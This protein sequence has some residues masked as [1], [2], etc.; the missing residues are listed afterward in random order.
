MTVT[1]VKRLERIRSERAGKDA[2]DGPRKDRRNRHSEITVRSVPAT[3]G[4]TQTGDSVIAEGTG[5]ASEVERVSRGTGKRSGRSDRE[6]NATIEGAYQGNGVST[7][8]ALV[9]PAPADIEETEE[10]KAAR[11]KEANRQ[12][13]ALYREREK[14]RNLADTV[15]DAVVSSPLFKLT[16]KAE[17]AAPKEPLRKL[18]NDESEDA[19]SKMTYMYTKFSGLLD[20]ILEAVVRDHEPVQIWQLSDDEAQAL[21]EMQIESGKKDPQAAKVVRTIVRAYDKLYMYMLLGPRVVATAKHVTE[22]KGFSLR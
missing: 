10:E 19:L 5:G 13:Q 20:E 1:D 11:Q 15:K 14:E 8:I 7:E 22:H 2:N 4:G 6:G 18:S 12:R 9:A 21:A 16:Q 3:I 17:N